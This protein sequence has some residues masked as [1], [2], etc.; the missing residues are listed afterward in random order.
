M[1]DPATPL[2][3]EAERRFGVSVRDE[4]AASLQ[5]TQDL[6]ELILRKTADPLACPPQRVCRGCGYRLVGPPQPGG[7][8]CPECGRVG[9]AQS[10]PEAVA[11]W[12]SLTGLVAERR[13]LR[14]EQVKPQ[15]SL[16]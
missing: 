14:R 4:E 1:D 2:I 7:D 8:R 5:T 13:G 6:Y 9:F 3:R 10:M 11:A 15:T 16:S 12:R